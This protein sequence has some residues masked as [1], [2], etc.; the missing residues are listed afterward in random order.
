MCTTVTSLSC[1]ALCHNS[2][3]SQLNRT[4]VCFLPLEACIAPSNIMKTSPQ[5]GGIYSRSNSAPPDP[6][7][8]VCGDFSNRDLPSTSGRQPKATAITY[9]V[10]RVSWT[11]FTKNSRDN[12]LYLVLGFCQIFCGS[13]GKH[14]QSRQK[15][16]ISTLYAHTNFIYQ[17]MYI[18][19]NMMSYDFFHTSFDFTVLPL[20]LS[21]SP[22]L[23]KA[24]IFQFLCS[25]Y[26]YSG[27]PHAAALI[28][29]PH[30]SL[31]LL[32][33]FLQLFVL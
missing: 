32:S 31:L 33:W 18:N 23:I 17:F 1:H 24:V 22:S 15:N 30:F 7:S 10:L 16:F 4:I 20:H 19:N 2:Q 25:N 21:P 8:K 5:A 13:W 6:V 26:L 27:I 3:V 29:P 11:V 14:C 12:F 28:S 9:N